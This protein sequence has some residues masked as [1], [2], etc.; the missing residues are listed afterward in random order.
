M[1]YLSV[2]PKSID[3]ITPL[4]WLDKMEC[5]NPIRITHKSPKR[6][7]KTVYK[8]AC[9]FRREFEYDFVQYDEDEDDPK[10]VA[11]LWLHPISMQL[12]NEKF[13]FPCIGATC[14][15][16]REWTDAPHGYVM[17]WI[18]FHP[19]WRQKG[20]LS[21]SWPNFTQEFGDFI[22]EPP[23]SRAMIGFL[24]TIKRNN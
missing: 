18:W 9:F 1:K 11:F 15:R 21:K 17:Q 7:R 12:P 13:R 19:Y 8:I 4:V 3:I 22:C 23:Y 2:N 10:H 24:K 6:Y 14:F 16:Y 5:N 20:L